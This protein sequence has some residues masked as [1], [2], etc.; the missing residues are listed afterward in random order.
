MEVC[1]SGKKQRQPRGKQL[2]RGAQEGETI[3]AANGE[4]SGIG[5][6]LALAL[7]GLVIALSTGLFELSAGSVLSDAVL[8]FAIAFWFWGLSGLILEFGEI[9]KFAAG[10]NQEGWENLL[11][12]AVFVV[13]A[14]ALLVGVWF[15]ELPIWID[16]PFKFVTVA[17]GLVGTLCVAATVDAFF[18]KPRIN[19]Q[20]KGQRTGNNAAK[21]RAVL[22]SI[23]AFITWLLANVVNLL[24]IVDR[25]FPNL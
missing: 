7:V 6:A 1:I 21:D 10:F 8:S 9:K 4:I 22:G 3:Y 2:I 13:P 20:L 25:L 14:V 12:S 11:I 19:G 15:F 24:V 5:V 18:I 23:G 16:L 17:L